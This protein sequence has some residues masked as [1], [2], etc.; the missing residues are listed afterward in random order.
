LIAQI[1][2]IAGP[3]IAD[4]FRQLLE[5]V[6]NTFTSLL[7]SFL[8]VVFAVLGA[9][10]AFVV[11][12]DTFNTVWDVHLP[13]GRSLKIRIRERL[14]PFVL[15][16][17]STV[18]VIGWLEYTTLLFDSISSALSRVTGTF[19][20]SAFFF[21]IQLLFSFAS[22]VFLFAIIFKQIPDAKIKWGDVWLGAVITGWRLLF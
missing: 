6:T 10:G 14:V 5:G 17:A 11:L 15:I 18:L 4:L 21:I 19:A 2:A 22:A 16:A 1:Q 12:Q 20:A 7:N 13:R 8:S 9:V 3:T